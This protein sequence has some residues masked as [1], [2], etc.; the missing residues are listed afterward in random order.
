MNNCEN[1]KFLH[2]SDD[3]IDIEMFCSCFQN[4]ETC[5]KY[6]EKNE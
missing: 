3:G 4:A 2:C 1:C 5:T 6:E